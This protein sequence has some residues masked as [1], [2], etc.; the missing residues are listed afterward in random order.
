MIGVKEV[1]FFVSKEGNDAWSGKLVEPNPEKSDGPFA[2]LVGT[3][4]AIRKLKAKDDL[5]EPLTVMVRSGKYYLDKTLVLGSEDSGTRDCPITYTAYPGEHPILSGG[6]KVTGWKPYK[7]R[8]LRCKLPEAKGGK[9]KFRQLFFNGQ[10][11]IRARYPNFDPENP[12]YGGWAFIEGPAEEGSCVAFKYKAGTFKRQWAK[13]AE[14]EVN[15]FI[16]KYGNNIAP[17][18]SIDWGRRVITLTHGGRHF[19][20]Y[21]WFRPIPFFP[22]DRFVVENVLEELDQ[23][24][25]WCL[26]TEEG[27]L[28]F[29]PPDSIEKGEVVAPAIDCLID[30]RG[31]SYI[32]ISGFTFTETTSGDDL[33]HEGTEGCGAMFPIR[34][35]KYCG[36]AIHMRGAEHC[37][38]ENNHFSA[39]G[40]NAIYL[41]RY[42]ARNIIR[43]NE[44]SYAG[45]NGVCLLGSKYFGGEGVSRPIPRHPIYNK[46]EDNHIHHCGVFNK[47]V[48]GVFLGLS[49][50]NVIGH[51][52]IEHMPHHGINL[53]S[54]GFGRNILEFN[55]IHHTCLEISDNGAI[56]SW[57]EDPADHAQKDAERS[58]HV[59]RY[60]FIADTRGCWVDEEGN[61]MPAP[62]QINGIYLDNFTSNCF[63]YGN[64]IVRSNGS[65][66]F[67]HMG[68]NNIIEN[69]IIVDCKLAVRYEASH[70]CFPQM[71]G[72]TISNRFCRNIFYRSS[73]EECLYCLHDTKGVCPTDLDIMIEQSDYNLIFNAD[74]GEY[75]IAFGLKGKVIH[76]TGWKKM[77][78]DVHS[79]TADPMFMDLKHD[80][81]RLK[82]ESPAIKLG[83]EPIDMT[84][85]GIREG[86]KVKRGDDK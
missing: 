13:P 5:K 4:D 76:L 29:W 40:G 50:G 12:L 16:G 30:L 69:N 11:Q 66:V 81:Y 1:K 42:N 59:I 54:S 9:W 20:R 75:T 63:V 74:G 24:G 8:I 56:N 49:Q 33:H 15:V 72:F 57:M 14:A 86:R 67:V 37:C 31:V 21:P 58:G 52:L 45:T 55:S 82:P 35:R 44:I 83:F 38:I 32:N 64:I 22:N 41:E 19:D 43:Q 70:N 6:R 68:K 65:G 2:T 46:V 80:D 10:R 51:N 71:S 53:G 62:D 26:D 60:N 61:F 79:V 27:M 17:I 34:G 25:E 78:F 28:Y 7:E 18:K 39:V 36:D 85:I 48:A 77:G 73:S 84:K 3:R 23:P 47:Y